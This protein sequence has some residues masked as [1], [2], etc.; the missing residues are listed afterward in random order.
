MVSRYEAASRVSRH[1]LLGISF[2]TLLKLTV[3]LWANS[4]ALLADAI[5]SASDAL[6][7]IIIIISMGI[8]KQPA[9]ERHPYGHGRAETVATKLL[10]VLLILAGIGIMV[11]A[12]RTGFQGVPEVPGPAAL[13]VALFSILFQETMFRYNLAMGKKLD[14][15]ALIS[16]AWHHRSDAMTSIASALGIFFARLGFPFLDP[17]AAFIVGLFIIKVGWEIFQRVVDEI[18]DAQVEPEIIERIVSAA[19]GVSQVKDIGDIRAHRHGAD[20]HISCKIGLPKELSFGES[21]RI[22]HEVEEALAEEIAN[23]THISIHVEPM[24]HGS[25]DGE[26]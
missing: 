24:G 15:Q 23:T 20:L 16:D 8:A 13:A 4:A 22:L 19:M 2:L 18:M 6:S 9:D 7:T 12:V 3:G 11:N 21:H 26:I 5:H 1:T 25:L 17:I 14:S 10:A